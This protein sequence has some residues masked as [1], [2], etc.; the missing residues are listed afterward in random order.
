MDPVNI[1]TCSQR[2][3]IISPKLVNALNTSDMSLSGAA[4]KKALLDNFPWLADSLPAPTQRPK[5][6][7]LSC[8]TTDVFEHA[9]RTAAY[10]KLDA[11][12][13]EWELT[14]PVRGVML[15]VFA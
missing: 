8:D 10:D 6:S 5:D 11:K 3:A 2:L 7:A 15:H 9:G 4:N 12:R 13:R 14:A 1:L